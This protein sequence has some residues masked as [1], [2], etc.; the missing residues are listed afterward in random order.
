MSV[1]E[2]DQ[3][4]LDPETA[5]VVARVRR[6]M[7]IAGVTT[8]IA[9]AAVFGVIGYRVFKSGERAA[10]DAGP[11]VTAETLML[12]KGAKVL[13][14]AI[15]DGRIAVTIE[16]GEGVEIRTFSLHTLKPAGDLRLRT[17]P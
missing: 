8:L 11:P 17:A 1:N 15:S 14:T 3:K 10:A 7:M 6:M 16:T 12:P 5:L 2:P 13:G 4:P 9:V